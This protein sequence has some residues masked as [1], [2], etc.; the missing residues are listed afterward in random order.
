MNFS[1]MLATKATLVTLVVAI[2]ATLRTSII[3]SQEEPFALINS[4]LKA[5]EGCFS[6]VHTAYE[7][8]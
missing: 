4:L 6:T 7:S 8:Q 5:I 3:L 2:G 1:L